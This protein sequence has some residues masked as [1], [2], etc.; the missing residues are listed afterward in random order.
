MK[1]DFMKKMFMAA[2]LLASAFFT[3]VQAGTGKDDNKKKNTVHYLVED[4]FK[5]QF[6]S[7]KFAVWT[8]LEEHNLYLVRFLY[9]NEGFIAYVDFEGTILATAR[10]IMVTQL[11]ITVEKVLTE[12]YGNY[13]VHSITE[14][15]LQDELN[16][17]ISLENN[18]HTLELKVNARGMVNEGKKV[19]K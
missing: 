5:R 2:V 15:V 10:N 18:K 19:K 13:N 9:N 6:P 11:P 12:A 1:N 17:L 8:N 14:L 4:A 16:Y 7:A 3:T